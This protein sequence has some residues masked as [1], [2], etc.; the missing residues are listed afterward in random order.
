MSILHRKARAGARVIEYA[1]LVSV[2]SIS[3]VVAARPLPGPLCN[4]GSR[5]AV[6]L[7]APARVCPGSDQGGG[8]PPPPAGVGNADGGGPPPNAGGGGNGGGGG[9]PPNAGGGGGGGPR[10]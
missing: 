5:V 2:I 7:G 6:L 4:V 1:L 3:L 8:G 9:P 10:K